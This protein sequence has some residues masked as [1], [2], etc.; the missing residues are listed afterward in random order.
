MITTE[1]VKT[2][3]PGHT[4]LSRY[5]LRIP[6]GLR[7]LPITEGA[8]AGK[9]WLDEFPEEL[10]PLRSMVRHDAIHYGVT[11]EAHEVTA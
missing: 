8:T 4:P 2:F 11:F 5:T 1:Q 3:G 7:V 6:A 9:Y 10:F